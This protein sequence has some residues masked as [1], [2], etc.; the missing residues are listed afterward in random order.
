MKNSR[1]TGNGV[2]TRCYKTLLQSALC[3]EVDSRV[4]AIS[5]HSLGKYY[6]VQA[7]L[8]TRASNKLGTVFMGFYKK[9]QP[10]RES[11][12]ATQEL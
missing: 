6:T 1:I 10:N 5:L 11:E 7:C 3:Q 12:S 2:L 9:K 4:G 8:F